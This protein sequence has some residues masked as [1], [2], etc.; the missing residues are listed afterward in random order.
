MPPA[1]CF[2][3]EVKNLKIWFSSHNF[4]TDVG[5]T[6]NTQ[7]AQFRN[8]ITFALNIRGG[9]Y[10]RYIGI[11]RFCEKTIR[12]PIR[13]LQHRY[14]G[15]FRKSSFISIDS[16]RKGSCHVFVGIYHGIDVI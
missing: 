13:F 7:E 1:G 15:N 12:T 8:M 9:R 14:I 6:T 16:L 11:L 10:N 3:E 4:M 2:R 5:G